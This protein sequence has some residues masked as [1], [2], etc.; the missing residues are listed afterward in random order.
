MEGLKILEES[1]VREPNGMCNMLL[2][3]LIG[4]CVIGSIMEMRKKYKMVNCILLPC[5]VISIIVS[6]GMFGFEPLNDYYTV[7]KVVP[8][9]DNYH[10]NLDKYEV[11]NTENEI[12]TLKVKKEK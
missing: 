10:I 4:L 8:I 1:I 9:E 7:L 12:I 6:M 11:I 2:G 5:F 3:I